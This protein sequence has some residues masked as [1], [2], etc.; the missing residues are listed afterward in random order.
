MY[1]VK[2]LIDEFEK[3][4]KLSFA[5]I[6]YD[7]EKP[8]YIGDLWRLFSDD[9]RLRRFEECCESK[10]IELRF[11]DEIITC[12]NGKAH[13][14]MPGFIGATLTW[15]MIEC[16]IWSM[17][18]AESNQSMYIEH[19]LSQNDPAIPN[20]WN[21]D[22]VTQGFTRFDYD[23]ESGF[24]YGQTDSPDKLR[25]MIFAQHGDDCEIVFRIDDIGQ[26]DIRFCAFYRKPQE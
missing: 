21:I 16:E 23:A 18:E 9:K 22:L 8:V 24:H 7:N 17:D 19:L 4:G 5:G 13:E 15:Q 6:H 20:G 1:T 14:R 26:F 3:A 11:E 10:D 2:R 12:G 25:E